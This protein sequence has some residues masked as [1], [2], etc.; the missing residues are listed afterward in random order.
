MIT[1][2]ILQILGR[3]LSADD[4]HGSFRA[5]GCA[6]VIELEPPAAEH[7]RALGSDG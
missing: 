1:T 6:V 7:R 2:T 4:I 5:M 3:V